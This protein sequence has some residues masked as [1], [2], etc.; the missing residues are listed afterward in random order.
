[1]NTL[2]I[3]VL[4]VSWIR[5]IPHSLL[6][7]NH[8]NK[9]VIQY[10]TA[11][12]IQILGL[13]YG[14]QKAFVYLMTYYPEFRNLFYYR[15]GNAKFLISFLCP[16]LGTL[17]ITTKTIGPG[18]FIQHGF[19]TVIAAKSIGKDC[20]INQQVTI[21]FSNGTDSPSLLDNVTINAGAKVIGNITVGANAK[22]GAGTVVVKNVPDNCTV[23]GGP[24]YV[25]KRDGLKVKEQL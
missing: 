12:W 9:E 25:V 2:R 3:I 23:V 21:G 17:Y 5:L 1:M 19:A 11:R 20:W 15:I 24:V 4:Y 8:T 6:F 16:K 10:D 18:L 7:N 22:V 14:K 13:K